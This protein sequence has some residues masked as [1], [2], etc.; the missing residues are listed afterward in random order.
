MPPREEVSLIINV[1]QVLVNKDTAVA[2]SGKSKNRA[3]RSFAAVAMGILCKAGSGG[4]PTVEHSKYLA[5]L[6]IS[7]HG[8]VAYVLVE[9][10]S[11]P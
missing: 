11:I 5:H 8:G 6:P 1:R 7:N 2:F 4:G 3:P 9:D 10:A